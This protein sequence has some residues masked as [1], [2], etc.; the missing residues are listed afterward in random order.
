[1]TSLVRKKI[2]LLAVHDSKG[3][4]FDTLNLLFIAR[5]T[6]TQDV[7]TQFPVQLDFAK[8]LSRIKGNF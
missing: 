6:I 5:T 3:I 1:M 8:F 4:F 2:M 7:Q